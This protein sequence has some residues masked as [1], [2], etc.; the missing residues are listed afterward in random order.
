MS[1]TVPRQYTLRGPAQGYALPCQ[2]GHGAAT[3]PD[4]SSGQQP[5][6]PDAVKSSHRGRL[7]GGET[8]EK[9]LAGGPEGINMFFWK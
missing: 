7:P 4:S 1:E 8:V 3:N 9:P 2:K 5:A 6:M